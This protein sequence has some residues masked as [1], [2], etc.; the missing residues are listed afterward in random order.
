M[1]EKSIIITGP[2]VL[3]AVALSLQVIVLANEASGG[4]SRHH[5]ADEINGMLSGGKQPGLDY[6]LSLI[7]KTI[8]R[9][10]DAP[11]GLRLV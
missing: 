5:I 11:P 10:P 1:Q 6:S 2:D 9:E 4:P 3:A 7:A 8:A